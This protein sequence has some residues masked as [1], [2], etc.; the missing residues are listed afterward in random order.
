MRIQLNYNILQREKYTQKKSLRNVSHT[1][2]CHYYHSIGHTHIL[3][4]LS[5]SHHAS[6]NGTRGELKHLKLLID[7]HLFC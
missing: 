6:P 5:L 2:Y 7:F 3:N 1:V 4:N